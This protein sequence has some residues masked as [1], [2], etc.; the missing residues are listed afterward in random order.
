MGKVQEKR[1]DKEDFATF[2]LLLI[3]LFWVAAAYLVA[4]VPC[5]QHK[6]FSLIPSAWKEI[7]HFPVL[8]ST[9]WHLINTVK[10]IP[11]L[12][13]IQEVRRRNF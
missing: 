4:C 12:G 7:L 1:N 9:E 10:I 6:A 13:N 2:S 3:I 5:K 11:S 8:Q